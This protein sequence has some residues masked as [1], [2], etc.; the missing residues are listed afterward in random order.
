MFG[1][2]AHYGRQD[3]PGMDLREESGLE[4]DKKGIYHFRM[5]RT[6]SK[7]EV[8]H[9][10]T[11]LRGWRANCDIKLILYFSNPN[12]PDIGEIEDV[13]KYVVAYTGKRNHTS[14]QE[15]TAIQDLIAG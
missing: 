13:F 8:Q 12:L 2:E 5:K 7:Q 1:D 11:L 15:K 9:S 14:Q 10:R 4:K 3:T 6:L